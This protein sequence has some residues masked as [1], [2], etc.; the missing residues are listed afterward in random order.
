MSYWW[1]K[2]TS[3]PDMHI[4]SAHQESEEREWRDQNEGENPEPMCNPSNPAPRRVVHQ[5]FEIPSPQK[6]RDGSNVVESN[7]HEGETKA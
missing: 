5:I 6:Q 3:T 2:L 1:L 4:S 7:G